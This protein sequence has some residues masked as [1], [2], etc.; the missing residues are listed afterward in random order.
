[1]SDKDNDYEV[2]YGRPPKST[3]FRK[4][5]SGNPK[6]RPKGARGVNASLRRELEKKIT[7]REG[8]REKRVLK[9]DALAM[10]IVAR[11]L[12]GDPKATAEILR[13]D[14]DIYGEA[15]SVGERAGIGAKEPEQIDYDILRDFFRSGADRAPCQDEGGDDDCS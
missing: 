1:M 8:N 12:K 15:D 4:G 14:R 9:S 13:L 10:G 6:G 5:Q 2:G 3:R 7:V 11:A